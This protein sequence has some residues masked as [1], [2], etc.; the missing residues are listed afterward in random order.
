MTITFKADALRGF[1][2]TE[3]TQRGLDDIIKQ[4]VERIVT[5][6]KKA[7]AEELQKLSVQ[8]VTHP[9]MDQLS[10]ELTIITQEP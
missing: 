6:Y 5:K 1:V 4:E 2:R 10:V 9:S 8:I 7:L 3:L